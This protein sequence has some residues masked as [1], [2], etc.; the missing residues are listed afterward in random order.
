MATSTTMPMLPPRPA[1]WLRS[2][3][4][5]LAISLSSCVA[6]T[7]FKSG[8]GRDATMPLGAS[9]GALSARVS[10]MRSTGAAE[11]G[12]SGAPPTGP[13][14]A[15]PDDRLRGEPGIQTPTPGSHLDSG[16][17]PPAGPGMTNEN[18][19]SPHPACGPPQFHDVADDFGDRLVV[20]G[21]D[22]LVDLDGGVQGAGERRIF[23]DRDRM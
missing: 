4:G 8:G 5:V 2:R 17:R 22:F 19:S 6:M 9:A 20:L 10:L 12:H 21:R 11:V 16:F 1:L 14:E 23:H 3:A 18:N 15:R 13:R 7:N